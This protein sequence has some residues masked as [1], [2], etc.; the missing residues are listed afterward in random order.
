MI[1]VLSSLRGLCNSMSYEPCHAGPPKMDRSQ[2][3]SDK[4]GSS[5]GGNG[6]SPQYTFCENLKNCI[7]GQ[8]D[9]IPKDESPRLEG[10]QYVNREE[11][12]RITISPRM[13]KEVGP[14]LP[15]PSSADGHLGCF[16]VLAIINS[17]V[18]NTEVH[19]SLSD[20]VSLVCMPRSGIVGS[21]GSS[22]SS[23]WDV[24]REQHQ[25]VYII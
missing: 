1:T 9:M 24:S 23:F 12:K 22:I 7:K 17:A 6:K 2:Q 25:N 19:V 20:L 15:Y 3:S 8:K 21:Y 16:H 18:M 11:W 14:Q 10:I 5:E 13:N 4:M